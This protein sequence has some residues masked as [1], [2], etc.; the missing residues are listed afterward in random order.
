M[1][2]CS[3][4]TPVEYP[5]LIIAGLIFFM[6]AF[7]LMVKGMEKARET[8]KARQKQRKVNSWASNNLI[9]VSTLQVKKQEVKDDEV[10][11]SIGAVLKVVLAIATIAGAIYLFSL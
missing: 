1:E 11:D 8:E 10:I 9:I 7:V 6:I 3:S 4:V 2:T 5:Y